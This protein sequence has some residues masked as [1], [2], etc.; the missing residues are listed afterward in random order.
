LSS[1]AAAKALGMASNP[2][3][4]GFAPP[5]V[6]YEIWPGVPAHGFELQAS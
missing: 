5:V 3:S 4:G 2:R 1:I 6:L